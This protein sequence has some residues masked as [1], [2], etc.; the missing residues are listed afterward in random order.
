[1]LTNGSHPC[2]NGHKWKFKGGKNCG[3]HPDASCSLPVHECE[4]CGDCDY[5]DTA[6]AHRI[7]RACPEAAEC[8]VKG[9]A[10]LPALH[11]TKAEFDALDE[12]SASLPTG[13]RPGKRWKRHDGAH[14]PAFRAAGGKPFWLVGEYKALFGRDDCIVA[15]WHIPVPRLDV[16]SSGT[17]A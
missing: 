2:S 5:G 14:D 4:R 13:A 17:P 12:Y 8:K 10:G 16:P 15:V 1:M 3:C 6:E 11:L 9:Y 7:I